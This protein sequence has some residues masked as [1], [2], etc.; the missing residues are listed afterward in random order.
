MNYIKVQS[1]EHLN[2]LLEQGE[3]EYAIASGILRSS[4]YITWNGT[5]TY[6]VYHYIDDTEETMTEEELMADNIG[7]GIRNGSFYCETNNEE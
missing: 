2:K 7:S 4:K 6:Y 3:H 1:L 5:D